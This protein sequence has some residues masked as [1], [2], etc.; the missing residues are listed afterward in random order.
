[1]VILALLLFGLTVTRPLEFEL[2]RKRRKL[3]EIT[4]PEVWKLTVF[5]S[6]LISVASG[7]F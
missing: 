2:V 5:V 3:A 1:M 6:V 4:S 7:R